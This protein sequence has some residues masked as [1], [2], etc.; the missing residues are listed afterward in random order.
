[1]YTIPRYKCSKMCAVYS[2]QLYCGIT[3]KQI[4]YVVC[5]LISFDILIYHETL[6]EIKNCFPIKN[7]FKTF[8]GKII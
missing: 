2:L 3:M 8:L 4:S 7:T 1:M 6:M 5:K